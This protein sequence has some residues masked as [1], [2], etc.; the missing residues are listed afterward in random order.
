[1]NTSRELKP[2]DFLC[3]ILFAPILK[4]NNK[5][6]RLRNADPAVSEEDVSVGVAQQ[7]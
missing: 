3:I 5:T 7:L 2:L 1:M 4:P 6:L